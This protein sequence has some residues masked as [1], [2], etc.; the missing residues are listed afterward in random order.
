MANYDIRSLQLRILDILLAF[1]KVC[2]AHN[3]RYYIMAG[4]LLG[5][6][7]HKGFIPWDD[8]IDVGMP[9]ADY[10]LLIANARQWLP[11]TYEFMCAENNEH[12]PYP[13]GKI[14]DINTTLIEQRGFRYKG[15][16]YVDVF[17]LD[18][19][20]QGGIAQKI[21]FAK[22]KLLI[23]ILYFTCRDPYRHGKNLSS[24]TPLLCRKLFTPKNI[25]KNIRKVLTKYDFDKSTLVADYDDKA[26]GIMDKKI[27]GVPTPILFEGMELQGVE[28]YDAYLKQKYGD[29]MQIPKPE[30]QIQH[31]FGYL[32]LDKSYKNHCD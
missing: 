9:R 3:L 20:P 29:Y 15:G 25:Q 19:V 14:Q 22:Y 28:N 16:I 10:D 1:D 12:Y 27:L 21:H 5:A 30:K 11:Q 7:R 17:P 32:N 26:K 13:F 18:G 31:K 24:L 23:K 2:K 8:D 4:T 6:V